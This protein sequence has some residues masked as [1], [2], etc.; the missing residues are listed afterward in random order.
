MKKRRME[1]CYFTAY[2]VTYIQRSGQ[3]MQWYILERMKCATKNNATTNYQDIM[4]T[5]FVFYFKVLHSRN[6]YYA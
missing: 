2:K 4:K 1:G 5:I 3:C 6:S